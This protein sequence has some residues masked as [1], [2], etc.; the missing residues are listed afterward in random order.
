MKNKIYRTNWLKASV[1]TPNKLWL[2]KNENSDEILN[3]FNFKFLKGIS[4]N[5]IFAYP[6]LGSLYKLLSKR[7]KINVNKILLT[8]GADGGIKSVFESFVK[9]RDSIL[10]LEPSFAMYSIYPKVFKAKDFF[11]EVL[12]ICTP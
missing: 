6:D 2:D 4:K 9:S 10:R 5:F 1:R 3:N 12:P 7:L 11:V 8:T